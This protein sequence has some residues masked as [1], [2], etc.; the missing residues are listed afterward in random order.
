MLKHILLIA[1]ACF[2]LLTTAGGFFVFG[3]LASESNIQYAQA[4]SDIYEP[5]PKNISSEKLWEMVNTYR[6]SQNLPE[7][8]TDDRLCLIARSRLPEVKVDWSHRGFEQDNGTH[9]KMLTYTRLGENL[10]KDYS[11]EQ[12][13]LNAWIN[14]KEHNMTMLGDYTHS[15]IETDGSY[16]VQIF[17]KY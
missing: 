16:A 2:V 15:C 17:A 7:T 1:L 4:N 9:S 14:S 12:E 10:A 13:I 5:T 3:Y 8:D 6:T 11:T